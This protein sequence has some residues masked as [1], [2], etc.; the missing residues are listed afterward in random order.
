VSVL[1]RG[2]G[3]DGIFAEVRKSSLATAARPLLKKRL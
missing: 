1:L 2:V 3:G